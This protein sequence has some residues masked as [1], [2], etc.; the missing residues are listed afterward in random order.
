MWRR[1]V[2]TAITDGPWRTCPG[3]AGQSGWSWACASCSATIRTAAADLHRG[4]GARRRLRRRKAAIAATGSARSPAPAASASAS[5]RADLAPRP[6]R[7]GSTVLGVDD[8]VCKATTTPVII[9]FAEPRRIT[10]DAS[11]GAHGVAG[12]IGVETAAAQFGWDAQGG[13]GRTVAI[14]SIRHPPRYLQIGMKEY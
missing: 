14:V 11:T 5:A 12:D 7:C 9:D 8:G 4:G 3:P 6:A 2:F 1:G 13:E 10:R